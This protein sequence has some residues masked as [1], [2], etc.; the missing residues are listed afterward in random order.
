MYEGKILIIGNDTSA[1]RTLHANLYANGFGV[2]DAEDPKPALDLCRIMQF[3]VALLDVNA[4]E[5]LEVRLCRLLRSENVDAA[6][7]VL[8]EWDDLNRKV[9]A[10]GAGADD[11]ILKPFRIEE[12][13]ARI[14]TILRRLKSPPNLP[15]RVIK[16]GDIRLDP[17]GALCLRP[18]SRYI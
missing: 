17:C 15:D 1:R 2:T 10:L 5:D 14:R 18:V 3:D 16:I 13:I 12:L 7:L 9:D 11:Y 8:S 4:S 6:I